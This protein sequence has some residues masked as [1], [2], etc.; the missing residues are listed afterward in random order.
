MTVE[1]MIKIL[2]NSKKIMILDIENIS[3][4][5]DNLENNFCN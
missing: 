5:A 3:D 1:K 2:N 4:S